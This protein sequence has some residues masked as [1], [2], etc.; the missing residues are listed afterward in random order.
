MIAPGMLNEEQE[1]TLNV[2]L[3]L[4]IPPSEDGKMPSAADVGFFA[5]MHNE[6]LYSWIREGLLSIGEETHNMYGKEFSVLSGSEQTQL[7]DRLRRKLFRFFSNLATQV[8]L[9]YYQ[10]DHVLEAIGLEAR[11]PFPHGYLVADGDLTLLEAVYE[12]GKIYRD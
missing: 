5:Y 10:H 9:C 3:N 8:M 2:L 6:N 7:I 12:R 11:P 4:I 1:R